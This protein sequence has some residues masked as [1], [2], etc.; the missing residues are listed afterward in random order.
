MNHLAL[1]GTSRQRKPKSIE[2]SADKGV[3]V[4][5]AFFNIDKLRDALEESRRD[6][7]SD[8]VLL[9]IGLL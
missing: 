9:E 8:L 3:G 5:A 4:I 1:Y 2:W 6:G 7:E